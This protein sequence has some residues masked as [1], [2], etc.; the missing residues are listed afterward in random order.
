LLLLPAVANESSEMTGEPPME[1]YFTSWISFGFL[2]RVG[3]IVEYFNVL[4]SWDWR[5]QH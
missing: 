5:D 2:A 1:K 4:K 3:G